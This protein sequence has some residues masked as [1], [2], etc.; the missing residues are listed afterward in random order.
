MVNKPIP[1]PKT[2]PFGSNVYFRRILER[3]LFRI[4]SILLRLVNIGGGKAAQ[5]VD[6][7]ETQ[8]R[9]RFSTS[10]IQAGPQGPAVEASGQCR[11]KMYAGTDEFEGVQTRAPH[12]RGLNQMTHTRRKQK[13]GGALMVSGAAVGSGRGM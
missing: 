3:C 13:G 10:G 8:G 1:K 11:R 2:V 5:N 4:C 6:Q 9:K 7:I 12:E